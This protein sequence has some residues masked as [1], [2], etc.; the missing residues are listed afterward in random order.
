LYWYLCQLVGDTSGRHCVGTWGWSQWAN[1]YWS[2][3]TVSL[4]KCIRPE[5]N[6]GH[7]ATLHEVP[8][9]H[10]LTLWAPFHTSASL[11]DLEHE[12]TRL[13][14]I[15]CFLSTVLKLVHFHLHLPTCD[16]HMIVV[17]CI[18][19]AIVEYTIS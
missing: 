2:T 9:K 13:T 8:E 10:A 14:D 12:T 16:T 11:P 3:Q 17:K 1:M 15:M 7:L 6:A 18:C 4:P 19:K 5:A